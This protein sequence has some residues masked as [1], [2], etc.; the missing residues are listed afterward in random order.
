MSFL[1]LGAVR[2][3]QAMPARLTR[4]RARRRERLLARHANQALGKKSRQSEKK[5]SQGET[6]TESKAWGALGTGPVADKATSRV[7]TSGGDCD[8]QGTFEPKRNPPTDN[9]N[10]V[11]SRR[12][13]RR[14]CSWPFFGLRALHCTI[15][16]CT[17]ARA[18]TLT[19]WLISLTHHRRIRPLRCR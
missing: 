15:S 11:E 2:P 16:V 12:R 17:H 5:A 4:V 13:R 8:C 14:G 3:T 6:Q 19:P 1:S 9:L 7:G 18:R 10:R